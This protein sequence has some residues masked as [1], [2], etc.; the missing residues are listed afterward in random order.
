MKPSNLK[1]LIKAIE[2]SPYPITM[3]TS[4]LLKPL[5]KLLNHYSV[6]N[7]K[8]I[9]ASTLI[10]D[11][12]I[13]TLILG[14]GWSNNWLKVFFNATVQRNGAYTWIKDKLR[15]SMAIDVWGPS[16]AWQRDAGS[17]ELHPG[18]VSAPYNEVPSQALNL[19][20]LTCNELVY[21][22]KEKQ[23]QNQIQDAA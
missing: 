11:L 16:K 9:P 13:E 4:K 15:I 7:L 5:V 12:P 2:S 23:N 19:L 17:I 6:D 18:S 20:S 3:T 22:Q 8:S 1:L 10:A 21:I 14:T